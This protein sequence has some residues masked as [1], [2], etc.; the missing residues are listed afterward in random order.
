MK[1]KKLI[2]AI[3]TATVLSASALVGCGGDGGKTSKEV[4]FDY[5]TP[6]YTKTIGTKTNDEKYDDI[7]I[8][9]VTGMRDDFIMGVDA[10]MVKTV[11]ECG[12]VYYNAEGKEQDVF[13]IMAE[14]G[15]NFFR[16]RV[17][18]NPSRLGEDYGGGNVDVDEAVA[19][20]KRAARV[21]M[22][23]LVDFHYSDFW[24]DP[25]NQEKPARWASYDLNELVTAVEE[26]T[27]ESLQ[28][29]KDEGLDVDMVQIGNEIN[30]GMLWSEGKI[31]FSAE[32]GFKN[33]ASLLSSGIKGANSVFPDAYTAIHLANGGNKDEFDTYFTELEKYKVN[34]DVIGASYY[35]FYHGSLEELEANLNNVSEKFN[36]PVYVAEIS[37][38]FTNEAP[39]LP[40]IASNIYNES[41]EDAGGY[42]TGIQGQAS[43]I[44][45]CIQSVASIKNNMGLGVFYW[46]P[47]WLPVD[48]A[49]WADAAS[50][51]TDKDDYSTWANQ[52]MFSYTGKALPSLQV[53]SKVKSGTATAETPLKVRN[54]TVEYTLNTTA[55]EKMPEVVNVETSLGAIRT[56]AVSWNIPNSMKKADGSYVLG[57]HTVTGMVQSVTSTV[58]QDKMV[59]ATVHVIENYISDPSYENQGES[60]AIIA[61]WVVESSTP[62]GQKVIKLDR[63]TDT[64]T[65]KTDL[66]WYYAGGAFTATVSQTVNNL[67]SGTYKLTSYCMAIKNSEIANSV[68]FFVRDASGTEI[69]TLDITEQIKGWG[70]KDSYYVP[71]VIENISL[72]GTCTIGVRISAAS[73]AWGHIDDW[74]LV[75]TD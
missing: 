19:M 46:E 50:G 55:N 52:A 9:P 54:S 5:A 15:V 65:G 25:E 53:F 16:V 21:G 2:A 43:A 41:F 51:R 75:K 72:N 8:N 47:A 70:S 58:A 32:D 38:G 36:K 45:D 12:G 26:Y 14:S 17:W 68:V 66:N 23:I 34:Y 69:A 27:K 62:A 61:P 24:A 33:L 48:G 10:S 18:N 42:L 35:P 13:E 56:A 49:S 11:E 20:S 59:T 37:Y 74:S 6:T 29:F 67:P 7:I 3:A 31:D 30:Y 40:L 28:K 64:R 60:D 57:T 4:K 73:G 63:K 1:N 71:A 44:R 39:T 22:N